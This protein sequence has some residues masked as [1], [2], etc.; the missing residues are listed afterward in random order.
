M[1]NVYI[2]EFKTYWPSEISIVQRAIDAEVI[3]FF[4][5]DKQ[6]IDR[7]L[8]EIEDEIKED[9][10]HIKLKKGEKLF[11]YVTQITMGYCRPLIKINIEK[12]LVYF[13]QDMDSGDILFETKG[14]KVDYLRLLPSSITF[15]CWM[16]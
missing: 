14:I 8:F 4:S 10:A 5:I 3:G 11:R 2:D 7:Y 15:D 13:L 16:K 6:Y 9:V 12:G 1:K